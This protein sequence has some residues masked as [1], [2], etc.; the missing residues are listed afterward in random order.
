MESLCCLEERKKVKSGCSTS[1]FAFGKLK[2][3]K[4]KN[5]NPDLEDLDSLHL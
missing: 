3:K 1:R 2:K 4:K 5:W